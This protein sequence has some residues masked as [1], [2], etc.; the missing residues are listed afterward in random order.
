M[1]NIPF[2]SED[3]Q[4]AFRNQ[5][6]SQTSTGRDLHVS[7]I[8]IPIVDFTP[9][10]SGASLPLDLRF[11]RNNFS[12]TTQLSSDATNTDVVDD[13]GFFLIEASISATHTA[14][15]A[16]FGN[17]NFFNKTSGAT[18]IAGAYFFMHIGA[19]Q[20]VF[21]QRKQVVFIPSGFKLTATLETG[22][23]SCVYIV[24]TTPVADINGNLTNPSGYDPQ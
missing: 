22:S 18:T 6:P 13:T 7:D 15:D 23:S 2:V 3:F 11:A 17:L 20:S 21:A 14:A 9:T 10:S 4:R 8:V 1:A 19:N 24:N 12:T 16:V 5:F